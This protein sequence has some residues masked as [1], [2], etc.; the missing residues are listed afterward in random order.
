MLVPQTKSSLAAPAKVPDSKSQASETIFTLRASSTM[1]LQSEMGGAFSSAKCDADGNLYIRK[2]AVDR[3]LLGPVAKIDPDGK[4]VA[5]FDP[6][7]FSQ[8]ALNR[9]DAFSPASDGGRSEERRVG[10]ECRSR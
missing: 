10:K 5:L 7:A 9:A 3:P 8:L 2:F 6:A 1:N 4:R